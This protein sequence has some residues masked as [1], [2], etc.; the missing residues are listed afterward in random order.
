M[1]S[2]YNTDHHL[3]KWDQDDKGLKCRHCKGRV[4]VMRVKH[5]V[6][7]AHGGSLTDETYTFVAWC[8]TCEKKPDENGKDITV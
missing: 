4:S 2:I 1:P 8:P 6:L 7:K 5:R 3:K